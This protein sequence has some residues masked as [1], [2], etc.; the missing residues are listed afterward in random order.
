MSLLDYHDRTQAPI[1]CPLKKSVIAWARCKEYRS[2][3][4][5]LCHEARARLRLKGE[6]RE[7]FEQKLNELK[8]PIPD[9]PAGWKVERLTRFYVIH[10]ENGELV[11]RATNQAECDNYLKLAAS[12]RALEEENRALWKLLEGELIETHDVWKQVD[13]ILA[14][15]ALDPTRAASEAETDS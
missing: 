12:V 15:D 9:A 5:C 7:V 13:E 2:D 14:A 1:D 3:Y 4:R 6:G 10:D 11:H 8:R